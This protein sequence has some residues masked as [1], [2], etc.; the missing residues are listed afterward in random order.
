MNTASKDKVN[1]KK[2]SQVLAPAVRTADANGEIDRL[3]YDA[4]SIL[5]DFGAE[6]VTLSTTDKIE[7]VIEHSDT[8]GS[9]FAAVAAAD[10]VVPENAPTGAQA[11]DTNGT[12][13]VADGNA[14]IPANALFGYKG[15]KR[16]VKVTLNF[17]GTHSTGTPTA[18]T[19][20]LENP[21]YS[22]AA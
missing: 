11:P 16:Y 20:I 3:G 17:S 6:G 18:V 22:P 1:D 5:F 12:V 15:S 19:A 13:F 21:L 8:S 4:L 7:G 10:I 2:V 14:D 9:G